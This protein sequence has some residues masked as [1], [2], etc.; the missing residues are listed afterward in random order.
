MTA[1]LFGAR[2]AA[3]AGL[4]ELS[5][6]S[7]AEGCDNSPVA[8]VEAIW[9]APETRRCGIARRSVETAVGWA[10]ERGHTELASDAPL[11]NRASQA[12][13]LSL[14][15]DGPTALSAIGANSTAGPYRQSTSRAGAEQL[16]RPLRH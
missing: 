10:K 6:R 4:I 15:F 7:Y 12:M 3:G 9:V 2:S 5:E 11:K 1:P 14:G 8:Y 16:P 13:N